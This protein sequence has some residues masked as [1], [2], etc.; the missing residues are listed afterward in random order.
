[1]ITNKEE[2]KLFNIQGR[3]TLDSLVSAT[4]TPPG[5]EANWTSTKNLSSEETDL[6]F[7][8]CREPGC[9]VNPLRNKA[10]IFVASTRD[11]Q[12]PSGFQWRQADMQSHNKFFVFCEDRISSVR[13]KWNKTNLLQNQRQ[14]EELT[15]SFFSLIFP[16]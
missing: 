8:L 10:T 1:M 13:Y 16:S 11:F 6:V 14:K 9:P 15:S 7:H 4:A 3:N 2:H 5:L 12:G